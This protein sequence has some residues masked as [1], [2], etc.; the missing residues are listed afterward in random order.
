LNKIRSVEEYSFQDY[1]HFDGLI[2]TNRCPLELILSTRFRV[3]R[4]TF[5]KFWRKSFSQTS[6]ILPK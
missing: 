6:K 3:C 2:Q 5:R 4:S 1:K